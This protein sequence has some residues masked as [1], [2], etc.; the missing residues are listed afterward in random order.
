MFQKIDT[1]LSSGTK[2]RGKEY[3]QLSRL[4]R[5][6][7]E[8]GVGFIPLIYIWWRKQ[9]ELPKRIIFKMD[10]VQPNH[11]K[12]IPLSQTFKDQ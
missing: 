3:A 5:A 1:L 10:D 6:T 4:G 8:N 9:I 12:N 11:F 2:W 7:L